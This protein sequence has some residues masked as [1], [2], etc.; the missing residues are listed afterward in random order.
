MRRTLFFI[1]LFLFCMAVFI[2][3]S[4][5]GSA[6]NR[7]VGEGK[8]YASIREAVDNCTDGDTV[9]VFA[10]T[11]YE[12]AINITNSIDITAN[13]G[14]TVIID[15]SNYKAE[16]Y[17]FTVESD[18]VNISDLHFHNIDYYNDETEDEARYAIGTFY[19]YTNIDN[20]VFSD[21]SVPISYI[22]AWE[23]LPKYG[24]ISNNNF[25]GLTNIPEYYSYGIYIEQFS[26]LTIWNNVMT[27]DT[28]VR[29]IYL[30]TTSYNYTIYGNNITGDGTCIRIGDSCTNHLIYNNYFSRNYTDCPVID[31]DHSL[32]PTDNQWY[33]PKE[34]GTNIIGGS[35]LG[36]NYYSD[37]GYGD[38]DGDGI[39]DVGY[40]ITNSSSVDLYPLSTN[41]FYP[42]SPYNDAVTYFNDNNTVK[43]TWTA[44]NYT[45]HNVMVM[46]PDSYP[47]SVSDGTVMQ[48]TSNTQYV[49]DLNVNSY[50]Y[51]SVF[52][53]NSTSKTYNSTGLDF[54]WGSLNISVAREECPWILLT[55]DIFITNLDGSKS[56]QADDVI[57]GMSLNVLDIP[58]GEDTI[59]VISA[60]GYEQRIYYEDLYNN[61]WYNFTFYLPNGVTEPYDP[62]FYTLTVVDELDQPIADAYMDIRYYMNYTGNYV[63]LSKLKTDSNGQVGVWLFDDNAGDK[64]Y[65]I[66]LN[67]TGYQDE[68]INFIPNHN[69]LSYE[70]LMN[71]K[72]VDYSNETSYY[73]AI[74]FNGFIEDGTL[75]VNYTDSLS[76]TDNTMIR[77]FMVNSSDNTSTLVGTDIRT[78]VNSFQYSLSGCNT[79]N[80][81]RVVLYLNHSTFGYVID[82]F[83]ITP[84][85][86]GIT[87]ED[88]FNDLF[89]WNYGTNP[90]GWSNIFGFFLIVICMFSFGQ[91]NSGISLILTG[92]IML[93]INS[94]IGITLLAIGIPVAFIALGVLVQWTISNKGG[95]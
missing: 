14:D 25:I 54:T 79:S 81:Y 2:G 21:V 40:I 55:F 73:T 72:E 95:G 39:G 58:Y 19:N 38:A 86:R 77:V 28:N 49:I 85:D 8:T 63:N 44:G 82:F 80:S 83:I 29:G 37:Y 71:F 52:S 50:G 47:S 17:L 13:P 92:F 89:E 68:I 34:L 56:Y 3:F 41:V 23:F 18:Y 78:Y 74:T 57:K 48:N 65:K 32:S 9:T 30:A 75:Y 94:V 61:N 24:N 22:D 45:S 33:I 42:D 6:T 62:E 90:F 53:Y 67:K 15:G 93:F 43:M 11:Y 16:E 60:T 66:F 84:D 88:R 4:L 64:L 59:F 91:S 46:S 12:Y 7:E 70:F 51:F 36:G 69:T 1:I 76:L 26:N 87:S 27:L 31:V 5:L 35:Y 10:G 20:C